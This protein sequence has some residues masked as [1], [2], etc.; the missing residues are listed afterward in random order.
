ML[1]KLVF[2][3]SNPKGFNTKVD[4]HC[5]NYP[6]KSKGLNILHVDYNLG[7]EPLVSNQQSAIVDNTCL[8][9]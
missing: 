1:I 5:A 3:E 8:V 9:S 6:N 7:A 2:I 4:T